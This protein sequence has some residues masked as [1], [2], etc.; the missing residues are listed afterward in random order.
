MK[1]TS[2]W[3]I[4][5]AA[6]VVLLTSV[7]P[8]GA[9]QESSPRR[10]N[11][12]LIMA[13]DMGWSDAGC[14]GG[15]ISTP[16]IDSLAKDGMRFTQ[17]YNCARCWTTRQS[18]LTGLYPHQMDVKHSV[19]LAEALRVAGYRTL[20]TGKWHGHPGE[21]T[22]HGFDRYYGL[23]SGSCNFFNPG[24]RRPGELE[25][26]KDHGQIRTWSIDGQNFSPYTPA[27]PNWYATDAFTDHAIAYLDEYADDDRP[28]FLF[29]SYTAPHH[30]L[31]A[32]EE[33]IAKYRGK[34][35]VGW[36][37]VRQRRW[38]R[39]NELGIAAGNWQLSPRDKIVPAWEDARDKEQWDLL[40]A[41]YAA[42][43]DRM[44]QNIGRLLQKIQELGEEDNTLVLFLSDNGAC[45]EVNNQ[46]P[47]IPPGPIDSYRTYDPPWANA[48]DTP[49]RKYKMWTH[50]GGICTPLVARW[51]AV[52]EA[53]VITRQPGHVIDFMPTFCELA[54]IEIPMEKQGVTIHPTEGQSLVPI[55]NGETRE[56]HEWLFW[57]HLDR[58]AV[59][60]RDWKLVGR[61]GDPHDMKIWE[62]YDLKTDRMETRNVAHKYPDRAA[63][64]A[65]A[66][67][68]WAERTK[69][70]SKFSE[71]HGTVSNIQ[72]KK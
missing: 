15:E 16:S 19:T 4:R 71:K 50:E 11:I 5:L 72:R 61:R 26:A 62:L 68:S 44:D 17:F 70:R 63:A 36:D 52:I 67:R 38:Q 57:E 42:M 55:L 18:L 64:M 23:T 1:Q 51:P 20:M 39:M 35:T 56:A 43:V 6:N 40:M 58:K 24:N 65:K 28:W 59:R 69:L 25:P 10:P 33:E 47:D 2:R 8:F 66:W 31:Q 3:K 49:F 60:R 13:D 29:V 54:G 37:V 45:A 14:Y 21:P 32:P 12:A 22:Q 41:V 27:D 7:A 53:G 34:Y 9:A 46:T 30:P 48:S